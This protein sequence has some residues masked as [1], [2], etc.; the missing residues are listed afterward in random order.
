MIFERF[1][2]VVIFTKHF[3]IIF[4]AP[5]KP[6]FLCLWSKINTLPNKHL[7]ICPYQEALLFKIYKLNRKTLLQV[8]LELGTMLIYFILR[9]CFG[10][11]AS[12]L[13]PNE[14]SW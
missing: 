11:P 9:E 2:S 5:K 7:R 8:A 12:R 4:S 14:A 10:F 6:V 13:K 1:Y 3:R